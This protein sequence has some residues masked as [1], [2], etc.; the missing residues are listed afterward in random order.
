[1]FMLFYIVLQIINILDQYLTIYIFG[2][3]FNHSLSWIGILMFIVHGNLPILLH[4]GWTVIIFNMVISQL[5]SNA[6]WPFL[7]LHGH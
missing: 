5:F 1:M 7:I 2:W 3:L 6:I 4:G